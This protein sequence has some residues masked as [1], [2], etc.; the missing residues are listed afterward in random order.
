MRRRGEQAT[1]EALWRWTGVDLTQIDG[2]AAP[3]SEAVLSE[4]GTD[5]RTFPDEDHFASW[6]RLSP[7]TATSA[8]K[9]LR[10]RRNGT[11]ATRVAAVLR[12]AA[13]TLAHSQTALSAYYRRMARRKGSAVAVFATARKLATLIFRML[14]YGQQYVDE[15][16]AAYEARFQQQRLRHLH[17]TAQQLGYKLVPTLEAV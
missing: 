12:M 2:L 3:A 10:R 11:G 16:A 14:R 17:Q 6:L 7:N 8:G 1:R 15:G 13:T 5:L 4:I 9:P